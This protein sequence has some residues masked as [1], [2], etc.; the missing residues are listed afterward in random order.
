[1]WK[2]IL[3][4][5]KT[6]FWY[7]FQ[8]NHI[9]PSPQ[10]KH[11]II[12]NAAKPLSNPILI[13]TGTYYGDTILA[14]LPYFE[15]IVSIELSKQLYE[16]AIKRFSDLPKVKIIHGCSTKILPEILDNLSS[17]AV[18]WLDAHY[19]MGIT[20]KGKTNTPVLEEIKFI[21]QHHIKNHIILI[22]DARCF[23]PRYL[24]K[25]QKTSGNEV[26]E[27]LQGYPT[28]IELLHLVKQDGNYYISVDKDIIRIYPRLGK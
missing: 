18:F 15:N 4:D 17:P 11:K 16:K 14:C 20:A 6:Y 12:I 1:M 8:T 27:S 25:I 2:Y 9:P 13:G 5:I 7:F 19:S 21:L 28:L 3:K 26:I 24:K 10:E 23:N 22:D